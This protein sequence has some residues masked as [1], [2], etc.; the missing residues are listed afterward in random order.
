MRLVSAV[1][2]GSV[3]IDKKSLFLSKGL[4]IIASSVKE[5][6][7]GLSPKIQ[8]ECKKNPM[9]RGIKQGWKVKTGKFF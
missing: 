1:F 2:S 8:V 7:A 4:V 9:S 3:A 5:K 6:R